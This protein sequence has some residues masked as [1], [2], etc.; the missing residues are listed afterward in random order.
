MQ[1]VEEDA[2][3]HTAVDAGPAAV[4]EE[5]EAAA[6]PILLAC[7]NIIIPKTPT[8]CHPPPRWNLKTR[9]WKNTHECK[10]I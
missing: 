10:R 6:M 4:G 8:T 1:A 7:H 2:A 9:Q 3:V 5:E